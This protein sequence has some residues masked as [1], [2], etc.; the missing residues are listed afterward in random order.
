VTEKC[1]RLCR[2]AEYQNDWHL[3]ATSIQWIWLLVQ[4]RINESTKDEICKT[5]RHNWRAR[6]K[7]ARLQ[8]AEGL[9]DWRYP[10]MTL[11]T[12]KQ[13]FVFDMAQQ[14]RVWYWPSNQADQQN[15]E[16]YICA[17][18][19]KIAANWPK[20]LMR[21]TI[22]D[23][24]LVNLIGS[25]PSLCDDCNFLPIAFFLDWSWDQVEPV[26]TKSHT[27]WKRGSFHKS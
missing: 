23:V 14:S 1:W 21:L 20:R 7:S 5:P 19:W 27:I 12:N 8:R 4:L 22:G 13:L 17:A 15:R 2:D 26:F 10:M 11:G 18:R 3:K 16:K 6:M 9:C 25:S 24:S